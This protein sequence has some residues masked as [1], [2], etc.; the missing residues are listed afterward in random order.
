MKTL[1]LVIVPCHLLQADLT[2][3]PAPDSRDEEGSSYAIF[4]TFEGLS[5]FNAT[6]TCPADESAG[7]TNATLQQTTPL[8]DPGGI[9]YNTATD[10]RVYTFNAATYWILSGNPASPYQRGTLRLHEYI[11]ETSDDGSG[12]QGLTAYAALLNGEQATEA[13]VEAFIQ[14]EGTAEQRIELVTSF[15]WEL[16]AATSL[17]EL[18][19]E[20]YVD[21]HD[22]IDSFVLDLSADSRSSTPPIPSLAFSEDKVIASWP[23]TGTYSLQTSSDLSDPD[24]WENAG[25]E[26]TQEN[27]TTQVT[28]PRANQGF[29]RLQS[30]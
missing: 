16:A 27:G 21:A 24:S 19:L 30:S 18:T 25:G 15:T 23:D 8:S 3:T 17:L 29:F 4:D 2:L 6:G 22:S 12:F 28:L 10:R 26:V 14:N 11:N 9:K 7:M 20:G 1:L 13:T 5:S